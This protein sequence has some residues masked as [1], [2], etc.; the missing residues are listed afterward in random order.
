[1]W[2]KVPSRVAAG[3]QP[4]WFS[5]ASLALALCLLVGTVE[6]AATTA[7]SGFRDLNYLW[8]LPVFDAVVGAALFLLWLL[9]AP[10]LGRWQVMLGWWS[11]FCLL[12][13]FDWGKVHLHVGR[14][15]ILAAAALV[16]LAL[17]WALHR[18]QQ[19]LR[20][21][22]AMGAA[23]M[24]ALTGLVMAGVAGEKY[25]RER[26]ALAQLPAADP[27]APN[28]LLIVVDTLRADHLDAYGYSRQTS[29]QLARLAEQGVLFE[30]AIAPSSWTLPSHASMMT[31]VYPH[32][33]H[34]E[35][36]DD[37][38]DERHATVA[39]SFRARGYRTAAFSGNV[40]FFSVK[41]GM[42]RGFLHFEDFVY[43]I[44]PLFSQISL[45]G[46]LQGWLHRLGYRGDLVG[47]RHARDINRRVLSWLQATE[48]RPF[49][50]ALNYFDVH[51][52]Y[53][54]PEP[55]RHLFTAEK[56]P[57]GRLSVQLN[58]Y[59]TMSPQEVQGEVAAYDGAIRYMD[60]SLKELWTQLEESGRLRNT[61]VV[62]TSDHGEAFGEHGLF[63]HGN[64]LCMEEIRVPLILWAPGKVPGNL[65]IRRP[66]SLADVPATLLA[67]A[68]RDAGFAGV[69]LQSLW[70][71]GA[72]DGKW[73]APASELAE[74]H[75]YP[76]A[77]NSQGPMRS[78]LTPEWHYIQGPGQREE[79]YRW[80]EDPLET[81][82]LS[83]TRPQELE[84]LR[85][86]WLRPEQRAPRAHAGSRQ[87]PEAAPRR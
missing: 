53:A 69:P 28:V 49:F 59:P 40:T 73:P 2:W 68:D 79:L 14:T 33:H 63:T 29:P 62:V 15:T 22:A 38:L 48:G 9:A 67:F 55:Y 54:P 82:E 12:Q 83:A 61:V 45:G 56:E 86:A 35:V 10:L 52:P 5:L 42:G 27:R 76:G 70:E 65:R 25:L 31:G 34:A 87:M 18:G 4:S 16:A 60:D 71:G 41:A 8:F 64:G 19:P 44:A 3:G 72:P 7:A 43:G 77:P 47:R 37:F 81:H 57:G 39:E 36:T 1:M 46:R 84:A 80:V 20:K 17:S 23:V 66:V 85:A 24:L 75:F 32:D 50:V 6:G 21:R 26:K 11:S 58:L 74:M 30:T 13:A 51:D 78:L